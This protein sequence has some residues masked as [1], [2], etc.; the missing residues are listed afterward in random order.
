LPNGAKF[1]MGPP[2]GGGDCP[3]RTAEKTCN[4][5]EAF[6]RFQKELDLPDRDLIKDWYSE[7]RREHLLFVHH[8]V[9]M[10][11]FNFGK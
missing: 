9:P 5:P 7:E 10:Y 4:E 1:A 8:N 2:I 6:K 3:W 11:G